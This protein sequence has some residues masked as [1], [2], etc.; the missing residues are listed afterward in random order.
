MKLLYQTYDLSNWPIKLIKVT[1]QAYQPTKLADR[2]YRTHA[3]GPSNW[4]PKP[5]KLACQ[6]YRSYQKG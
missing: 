1:Y 3:I 4:P 6:A 2:A 5:I